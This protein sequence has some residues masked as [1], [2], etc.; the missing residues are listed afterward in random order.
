MKYL[1]LKFILP[2][3][4]ACALFSACNDDDD[5]IT[6]DELI[7]FWVYD[8]DIHNDIIEVDMI[9]SYMEFTADGKIHKWISYYESSTDGIV[10]QYQGEGTYILNKNRVTFTINESTTKLKK[11]GDIFVYDN[12]ESKD[13]TFCIKRM[14]KPD[15]VK[16]E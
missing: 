6:P 16:Y 12:E 8:V 4:L 10:Y 14:V 2:A 9:P 7:G 13:Y 5:N 11:K 15:G 1:Q 3:L